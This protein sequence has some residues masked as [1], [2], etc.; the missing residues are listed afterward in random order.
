MAGVLEFTLH[1][2]F[3]TL[4]AWGCQQWGGTASEWLQL[5]CLGGIRFRWRSPVCRSLIWS[6]F[7][8]HIDSF[9]S[10]ILTLVVLS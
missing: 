4:S 9:S 3:R 6:P 1:Q 5:T 10:Y 7:P 8:G 2:T